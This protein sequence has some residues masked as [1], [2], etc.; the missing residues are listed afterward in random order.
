MKLLCDMTEPE[1][2]D[3]F[4]GLARMIENKLPPGP[5]ARGKCLFAL[6]VEPVIGRMPGIGEKKAEKVEQA[7]EKYWERRKQAKEEVASVA[8]S[9]GI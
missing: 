4:I 2:R 6:I 9:G 1:L 3:Y 5:S 7:L 8:N